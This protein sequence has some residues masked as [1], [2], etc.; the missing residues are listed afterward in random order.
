[1]FAKLTG[2]I[3][4]TA[5]GSLIL[6]VNGVGYFVQASNRTLSRI[7]DSGDPCALLV[8]TIVREDNISLFGFCDALEKH[9]FVT[10]TKVQGVG[11]KAALAILTACPPE[12]LGAV[13][14]SQDKAAL[15]QADGVGPKL[16]A[17]LITELKDKVGDI[18]SSGTEA[19]VSTSSAG[20]G[21][22]ATGNGLID[23]ALSALINLGYGRADAF[24]ALSKA[25][26]KAENDNLDLSALIK[27]GLQELNS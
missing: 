21:N 24:T 22:A 4:S 9:W 15:T 18:A 23:D 14:A 26:A 1:M 11:A 13:I 27:L 16:A 3:D 12:N 20:A 6:D 10:L 2:I 7:G 19:S 17:R 5:Q 8:E 25:Q